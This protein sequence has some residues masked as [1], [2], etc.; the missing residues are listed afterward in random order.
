[1]KIPYKTNQFPV[2]LIK[3]L[4]VSLSGIA[5][6]LA[7]QEISSAQWNLLFQSSQLI[8]FL[9]LGI[10]LSLLNWFLEAL[11]W[12]TLLYELLT[13]SFLG[14]FSE[15]LKAHAISI[16]TPNKIGEFGAKASFYPKL[17]RTKILKMTLTGQLYQLLATCCFGILGLCFVYMELES[18]LQL[19]IGMVLGVLL[20]IWIL[21][22]FSNFEKDWKN[23]IKNYVISLSN[24][25]KPRNSLVLGYSYLR[26]L[27]FSHQ[28]YFFLWLFQPNL[29]YLEIMPVI[30]SIYFISSFIPT[31]LI[32]DA[33]LKAGLGLILLENFL[34]PEVIIT[35]MAIMWVFNFGIP[36]I[37][38]NILLL[39]PKH[40]QANLQLN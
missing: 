3:L 12:K 16:I 2:L 22:V 17:Y 32:L 20:L 5:I 23:K 31:F 13:V 24:L 19:S 15:S 6:F 21:I 36:A 8:N 34:P 40:K 35:S 28:L 11:K 9:I 7:F 1:M 27:C 39:K 29:S 25:S 33:G 37:I 14:A 30:F 18:N 38:G 26:Y 4:G 10:G